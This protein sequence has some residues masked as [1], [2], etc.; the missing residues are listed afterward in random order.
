MTDYAVLIYGSDK[1]HNKYSDKIRN[2]ER[3][4]L[5]RFLIIPILNWNPMIL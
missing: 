1:L 3:S 2:Y 5:R 4:E